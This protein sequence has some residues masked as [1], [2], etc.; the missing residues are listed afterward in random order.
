M[1]EHQSPAYQGLWK[2]LN[3][4][5][6]S[7]VVATGHNSS[8]AVNRSHDLAGISAA[9]YM[10]G[11]ETLTFE[12]IDLGGQ[13]AEYIDVI[14]TTSSVREVAREIEVP[15]PGYCLR[16][17]RSVYRTGVEL[18]YVPREGYYH[19]GHDL[20][21]RPGEMD[22]LDGDPYYIKASTGTCASCGGNTMAFG[23]ALTRQ[24]LSSDYVSGNVADQ[25][26]APKKPA[27]Q[28]SRMLYADGYCMGCKSSVARRNVR[29]VTLDNGRKATV[30]TCPRSECGQTVYRMG[31]HIDLDL[32]EQMNAITRLGYAFA[33]L[34]PRVV[35]ARFAW[36]KNNI[37]CDLPGCFTFAARRGHRVQRVPGRNHL[38]HS[39]PA[40]FCDEHYAEVQQRYRE[41]AAGRAA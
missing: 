7:R 18:V 41:K 8:V 16:C 11:W 2:L 5:T 23:S 20:Y 38:V 37:G 3:G 17:Q 12:N 34:L 28:K 27:V 19:S 24:V 36:G 14:A 6:P 31:G 15:T 9:N 26:P 1:I 33:Y 39:T 32:V 40:A 4:A 29:L 13:Y 21:V 22:D 30:G 10:T 25:P 35:D